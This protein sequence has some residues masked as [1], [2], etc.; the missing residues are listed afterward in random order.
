MYST[1]LYC[2]GK[3]GV[4]DCRASIDVETGKVREGREVNWGC[5][6]PR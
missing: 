4:C 3:L 5:Y 2:H 1:R 6:L